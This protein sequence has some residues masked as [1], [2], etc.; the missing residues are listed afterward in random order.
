MGN[1]KRNRRGDGGFAGDWHN[2][3]CQLLVVSFTSYKTLELHNRH[4]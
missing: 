2:C 1:F 4:K 3:Y